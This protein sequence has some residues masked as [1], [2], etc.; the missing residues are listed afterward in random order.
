MSA[1]SNLQVWEELEALAHSKG[2]S[3]AYINSDLGGGVT[4]IEI[5]LGGYANA[6]MTLN[7]VGYFADGWEN[8]EDGTNPALNFDT[9]LDIAQEA[10]RGFEWLMQV[11]DNPKA[12]VTALKRQRGVLGVSYEE[13]DGTYYVRTTKGQFAY[14]DING[15]YAWHDEDAII[16]GQTS[17]I[18]R[19]A[20]ANAFGLWLENL[21]GN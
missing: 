8:D 9:A 6:L 7:G 3:L 20:I 18:T 2:F 4:A 19:D 12:M 11:Q 16:C 15:F 14:G 21:G 17:E 13:W 10:L 5:P 1:D